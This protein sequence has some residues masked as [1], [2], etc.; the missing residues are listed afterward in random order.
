MRE[1]LAAF[2]LSLRARLRFHPVECQTGLGAEIDTLFEQGNIVLGADREPL[3]RATAVQRFLE[4]MGT[5]FSDER[6]VSLPSVSLG[7]L[8]ERVFQI[9]RKGQRYRTS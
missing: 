5:E 7:Q 8:L 9:I 6:R 4:V 2:I 3:C 1:L